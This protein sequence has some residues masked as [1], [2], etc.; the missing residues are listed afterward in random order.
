MDKLKQFWDT[1]IE[2]AKQW[3]SGDKEAPGETLPMQRIAEDDAPDLPD[4]EFMDMP[5]AK[6]DTESELPEGYTPFPKDDQGNILWD[7]VKP[8]VL[9]GEPEKNPAPPKPPDEQAKWMESFDRRSQQTQEFIDFYNRPEPPEGQSQ[10]SE[11]EFGRIF[12]NMEDD[13]AQPSSRRVRIPPELADQETPPILPPGL[14]LIPPQQP[15]QQQSPPQQ[16]PFP[17]I[18]QQDSQ[19]KPMTQAQGDRIIQILDAQGR[20]LENIQ[21]AIETLNTNFQSLTAAV[22][23]AGT[24]T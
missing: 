4:L 20:T 21:K 6:A 18:Q 14:E 24:V 11:N 5:E 13:Q 1:I 8:E 2:R 23:Q 19:D 7:Q 9:Y 12:R 3:M 17:Q 10:P 15:G 22:Q 16:Q